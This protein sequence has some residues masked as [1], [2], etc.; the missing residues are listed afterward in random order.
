MRH[1]GSVGWHA[2]R[3]T[4]YTMSVW[5]CCVGCTQKDSLLPLGSELDETVLEDREDSWSAL[6]LA[7]GSHCFRNSPWWIGG[8][9]IVQCP[10]DGHPPPQAQVFH[11]AP[12][13]SQQWH[14]IT[15]MWYLVE[16]LSSR[17]RPLTA[18][19]CRTQLSPCRR[20]Q[21]VM[22]KTGGVVHS[23]VRNNCNYGEKIGHPKF[24]RRCQ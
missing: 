22:D 21:T 1:G 8:R 16:P 23:N 9:L 20:R 3:H 4:C 10:A 12:S 15:G 6:A 17:D 11:P 13:P 7:S 18:R 2:K 14:V 5:L 24:S 19:G